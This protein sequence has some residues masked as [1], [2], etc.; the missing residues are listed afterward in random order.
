MTVSFSGSVS[1]ITY[2]QQTKKNKA[3]KQTMH[4]LHQVKQNQNF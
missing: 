1:P 3:Q 4:K 2:A